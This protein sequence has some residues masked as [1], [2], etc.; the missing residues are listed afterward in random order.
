MTQP[1]CPICGGHV[2][3]RELHGF[4]VQRLA[5]AAL[6]E[7]G[8]VVQLEGAPEFH[9]DDSSGPVYAC[10]GDGCDFETSSIDELFPVGTEALA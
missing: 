4:E 10:R 5:G 9:E 3:D 7:H 1:T 8:S 6:A 2:I